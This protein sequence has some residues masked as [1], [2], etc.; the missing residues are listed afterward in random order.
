MM[1]C[2]RTAEEKEKNNGIRLKTLSEQFTAY[3][4]WVEGE[5]S[6]LVNFIDY[7]KLQR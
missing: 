1:Q 5:P 2:K 3:R 4:Q 6:A 7:K